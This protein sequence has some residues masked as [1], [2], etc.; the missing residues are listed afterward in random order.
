MLD[1]TINPSDVLF[2]VT[3][4]HVREIVMDRNGWVDVEWTPE[5]IDKHMREFEKALDWG[6]VDSLHEIIID[7]AVDI[8]VSMENDNG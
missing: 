1:N 5:L 7:K 8:E 3:K 6:M 4:D 2:F